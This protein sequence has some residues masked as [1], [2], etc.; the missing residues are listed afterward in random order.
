[1]Q[2][3]AFWLL[4]IANPEVVDGTGPGPACCSLPC[5]SGFLCTL[6]NHSLG[7]YPKSD[8]ELV[9]LWFLEIP[10]LKLIDN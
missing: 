3:E 6:W 5:S 1:M 2:M 8:V 9:F 7:F 4:E 10:I